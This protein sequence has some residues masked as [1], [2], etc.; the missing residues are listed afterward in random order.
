MPRSSAAY[1]PLHASSGARPRRTRRTKKLRINWA[2]I[3]GAQ[4]EFPQVGTIRF[5]GRL[6]T[7]QMR[8]RKHGQDCKEESEAGPEGKG[9]ARPGAAGQNPP[10]DDG[11]AFDREA[12]DCQVEGS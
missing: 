9:E 3:L 10:Q 7:G 11:E 12:R 1:G 8:E 4:F 5:L 2:L 6:S